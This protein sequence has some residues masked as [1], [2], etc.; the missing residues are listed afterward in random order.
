MS[1]TTVF[2]I[3]EEPKQGLACINWYKDDQTV[4]GGWIDKRYTNDNA[5]WLT[6]NPGSSYPQDFMKKHGTRIS[7]CRVRKLLKDWGKDVKLP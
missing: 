2:Y 7:R 4:F 5:T 6:P 3:K 1:H